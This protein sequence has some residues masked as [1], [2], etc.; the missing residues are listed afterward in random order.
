MTAACRGEIGREGDERERERRNE[1]SHELVHLER[2]L[3]RGRPVLTGDPLIDR[4]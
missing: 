2:P 3:E 4:P 1:C